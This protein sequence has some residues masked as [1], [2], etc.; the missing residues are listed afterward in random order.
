MKILRVKIVVGDTN[1]YTDAMNFHK[2]YYLL[3]KDGYACQLLMVGWQQYFF[4]RMKLEKLPK[5]SSIVFS[6][7]LTSFRR[8]YIWFVLD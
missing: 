8:N 1:Q 5:L 3:S 4:L 2:K 7:V 6:F